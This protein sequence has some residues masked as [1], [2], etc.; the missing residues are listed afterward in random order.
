MEDE[1]AYP[2][3]ARNA[4][5]R[6]GWF[7]ACMLGALCSLACTVAVAQ[8][9]PAD[10]ARLRASYAEV[11]DKMGGVFREP[12]Y[13]ESSEDSGRVSG[14]IYARMNHS[15]ATVAGA[16]KHADNWCEVMIL[17]LNTKYCR[18]N[19]AGDMLAMGVGS[20]TP[21][22]PEKASRLDFAFRLAAYSPDYMR[23]VLTADNG[24]MGTSHYRVTLEAVPLEGGKT[25]LHFTY[26]Y[27]VGTM[28]R[29]AMQAYLATVGRGK[30]GFTRQR[31]DGKSDY[32]T[33]TRAVVERNTMRYYLAIEAYLASLKAPAAEQVDRRIAAWYDATE[34]YPRQLHE[35]DR[36]AYIEMKH[37]EVRRQQGIDVSMLK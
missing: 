3:R 19:P 22:A 5:V 32:I 15:F 29:F 24:P 4:W 18:A 35:V 17:H 36:N 37:E 33:G 16:L 11:S 21:E 30:V 1:L 27:D 13:L 26:S 28:G 10:A 14:D 7:L 23:A 6:G 20:K 8:T 34:R 9:A 12:L 2:F 25:F 31:E